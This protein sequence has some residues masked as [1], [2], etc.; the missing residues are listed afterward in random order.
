M[1][2]MMKVKNVSMQIGL[3]II[4]VICVAVIS[5]KLFFR[6]DVTDDN[7]YTLSNGSLSIAS[8]LEDNVVAKLY[9][10]KSLKDVPISVKAYGTRVGEVL[11][12]FAAYSNGLMSVDIIDPKPDTDEEVWARNYGVEGAALP[13]GDELFLG[14][15]FLSGDKEIVIPYLDPRKEEFLEY[16]LAEALV[17]LKTETKPKIGVMSSLPMIA[18]FSMPGQRGPED[19]AIISGL[20]NF[21]EVQKI[22]TT[23]KSIPDDINIL[24]VAHAKGLSEATVYA[25]D[26][27]VMRGGRMIVAVDPFSRIDIALSRQQGMQQRMPSAS[28]D[29]PKL[30]KAWGIEYNAG[31]MVGDPLRA[32]RI[33]AGAEPINYPFFMTLAEDSFS[34]KDKI[35]GHLKQMMIAEG[36]FFSIKEGSEY[37]FDPLIQTSEDT[38]KQ[39]VMMVTFQ[40]PAALAAAFKTDGQ[41]R[42]LAGLLKGKFKSAFTEAPKGAEVKK[43]HLKEAAEEGAIL[44]VGDVDFI[45]DSNAVNKFQFGSQVIVR[46]MNDNLNFVLNATEFLGGNHDLISIRSSGRISRPFT[47]V[48]E[49]QKVAQEQWKAEE[50][51]LS[52]E[53]RK[54]QD[55]LSKMQEQRTDANRA[56]LSAEQQLEIKRFRDREK[57]IR[58]GL[59]LVRKNLREDIESLGHSLAAANLLIVPLFASIFGFGVF[60]VRERRA[61]REKKN[62]K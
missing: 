16:D 4:G 9:F 40:P 54:L 15:V 48:L 24:F 12:E 37:K 39:N 60:F 52:E 38:G 36:G 6:L 59:R 11:R 45:H 7:A 23:A 57:E 34:T 41:K 43:A 50:D 46:P 10:S 25:L 5:S 62:G 49:I 18:G 32:T 33:S 51:R 47:K 56:A 26:Q 19:W 2:K 58:N 31:E 14:V 44:L 27:F 53:L 61:R 29:I 21:F 13:S 30:F 8:K 17:K 28:S 35:T 3:L 1:L 42:V 22:E 55:D 20:K